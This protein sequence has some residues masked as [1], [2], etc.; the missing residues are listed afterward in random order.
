MTTSEPVPDEENK[1]LE[2]PVSENRMTLD[3]PTQGF[4]LFRT[5]FDLFHN[6]NQSRVRALKL[7]PLIEE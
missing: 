3:T 4:W 6:V 7:K 2:E 1:D 5:S